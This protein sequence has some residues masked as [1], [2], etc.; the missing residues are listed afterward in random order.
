[1]SLP[2]IIT[3]GRVI[4]VPIIFWLL[5]TGNSQAAFYL[6]VIAGLSDAPTTRRRARARVS[7][8]AT[9]IACSRASV[10]TAKA[11]TL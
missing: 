10:A 5:V 7:P 4:L 11:V 2:N 6:V 1:M 3:L 8:S 9:R